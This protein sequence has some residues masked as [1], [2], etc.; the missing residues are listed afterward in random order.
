MEAL[1]AKTNDNPKSITE[2][3]EILERAGRSKIKDFKDILENDYTELRKNLDDLKPHLDDL[4]STVETEAK[5]TKSQIE[6]NIKANPWVTLGLVGI[7]AFVIGWIFGRRE[8][9]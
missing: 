6:D 3:I 2:A 1:I 8:Q 7:I 4:K 5:K 9:D